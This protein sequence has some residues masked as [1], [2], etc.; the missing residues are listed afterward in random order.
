M[1][2]TRVDARSSEQVPLEKIIAHGVRGEPD[3]GVLA[4]V[5]GD[6]LAALAGTITTM[7]FPAR[8]RV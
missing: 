3:V 2:G 5:E 8:L 7:M 6:R 4:S 1:T